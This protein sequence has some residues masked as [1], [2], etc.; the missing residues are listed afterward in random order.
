MFFSQKRDKGDAKQA[1][2]DRARR[3]RESRAAA[4]LHGP[5]AVKLQAL[6]RGRRAREAAA[7]LQATTLA[8]K[9]QQISVLTAAL[10]TSK[11]IDFVPP[12][13]ALAGLIVQASFILRAARTPTRYAPALCQL[14]AWLQLHFRRS[15]PSG[16]LAATPAGVGQVSRL[17][18]GVCYRLLG[19][20]D[21]GLLDAQIQCLDFALFCVG[22]A[23]SDRPVLRAAGSAWLAALTARSNFNSAV[24]RPLCTPPAAPDAERT[25]V[26]SEAQRRLCAKAVELAV[27]LTDAAAAGASAGAA[28]GPA[29]GKEMRGGAVAPAVRPHAALLAQVLSI[30]YVAVSVAGSAAH[31]ALV[32]PHVLHAIIADYSAAPVAAADPPPGFSGARGALGR[33]GGAASSSGIPVSAAA[34]APPPAAVQWSGGAYLLGNIVQL[35][36]DQ[37]PAGAAP[38]AAQGGAAGSGAGDVAAPSSF[39]SAGA[40]ALGALDAR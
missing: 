12:A 40:G 34:V 3:E 29:R 37:P 23:Q 15:D 13:A 1:L 11:G 16:S 24:C 5:L 20:P 30:P 10:K 2:V 28:S 19:R 8:A 32:N 26:P 7:A 25:Y 21:V 17:L 27:I 9:L 33:S 31:S 18:L 22:C 35:L 4:Q 6:Y 14:I 36:C 39:P 38:P